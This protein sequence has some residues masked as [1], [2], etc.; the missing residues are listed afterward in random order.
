MKPTTVI[1]LAL[2][3]VGAYFYMQRLAAARGAP[4]N[5][6]PSTLPIAGAGAQ[7]SAGLSAT[8]TLNK[9]WDN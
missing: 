5:A 4:G 1:V 2:G 7:P 8:V 9:I 3:I 6:L